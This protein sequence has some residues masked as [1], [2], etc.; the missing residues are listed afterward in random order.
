M[1]FLRTNKFFEIFSGNRL[2]IATASAD[3]SVK[4]WEKNSYGTFACVQTLEGHLSSV[5]SVACLLPAERKLA[6]VS[7]DGLLKV[8]NFEESASASND[9]GS[10]EA[11]DDKVDLSMPY[12]LGSFHETY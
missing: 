4:L 8:W 5:L 3:A 12:F 10:F 6:T 9:I 1:L 7:S 11:H 2:L